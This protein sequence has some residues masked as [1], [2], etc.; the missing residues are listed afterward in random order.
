MQNS[1]LIDGVIYGTN[2][3]DRGKRTSLMALDAQTGKT[4]WNE[5]G[6][7]WSQITAI[8]GYLF[9]LNIDGNLKI[10]KADRSGYNLLSEKKVFDAICWTKIT[11]SN[12][13][14]FMRSNDGHLISL[15][16]K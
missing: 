12:G 8:N 4:L 6:F 13:N 7:K 10:I 14:I 9:C 15:K 5:K 3:K 2:G 1:I 11:Y 16:I